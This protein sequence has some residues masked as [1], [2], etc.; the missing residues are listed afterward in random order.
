MTELMWNDPKENLEGFEFNKKRNIGKLFGKDVSE[1][2]CEKNGIKYVIRSH[3]YCE[4][5]L[6]VY[7]YYFLFFLLLF[8]DNAQQ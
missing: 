1:S 8:I 3:Q 7:Y 4:D 6:R 2:F 5:G